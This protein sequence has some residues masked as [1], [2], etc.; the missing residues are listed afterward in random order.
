M[1]TRKKKGE[2]EEK[3]ATSAQTKPGYLDTPT[4]IY[5]FEK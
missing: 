3:S 5:L 1:K 2:R 4:N